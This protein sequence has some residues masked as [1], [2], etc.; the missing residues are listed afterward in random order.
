M[1]WLFQRWWRHNAW[2]FLHHLFWLLFRIWTLVLGII[3]RSDRWEC[4]CQWVECQSTQCIESSSTLCSFGGFQLFC[5]IL[6]LLY[7]W[8]WQR[9]PFSGH[10]RELHREWR[11]RKASSSA[12]PA[13][14]STELSSSS[15]SLA[16]S[17]SSTLLKHHLGR[18]FWSCRL[19]DKHAHRLC[20][21]LVH[22]ALWLLW[23]HWRRFLQEGKKNWFLSHSGWNLSFSLFLFLA[24][25]GVPLL[26]LQFCIQDWLVSGESAR[27]SSGSHLPHHIASRLNKRDQWFHVPTGRLSAFLH[28]A[29][30]VGA[31]GCLLLIATHTRRSLLA[32]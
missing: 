8:R 31:R 6:Q 23:R 9:G 11:L 28:A 3:P 30:L 19:L 17:S 12:S 27:C 1:Q 10:A 18:R 20:A 26:S 7:R 22:D 13:T 2:R 25:S 4:R 32:R 24:I 15:A 16:S 14:T 29:T 21:C 5:K